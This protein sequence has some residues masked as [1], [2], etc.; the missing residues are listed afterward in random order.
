MM[1]KQITKLYEQDTPKKKKGDVIKVKKEC[2]FIT[3]SVAGLNR[4]K[5]DNA[6]LY[7]HTALVTIREH[8]YLH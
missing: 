2:Y 1:G 3:L 5:T 8:K 4:E 6:I 7:D